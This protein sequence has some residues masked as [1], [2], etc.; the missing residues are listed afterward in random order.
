MDLDRMV[1]T[2]I[3]AC[4]VCFGAGCL[5][6]ALA[7]TP[8]EREPRGEVPANYNPIAAQLK[9]CYQLLTTEIMGLKQQV[10]QQCPKPAEGTAH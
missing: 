1:P 3:V 9:D 7:R 10:A 4:F 5:V 8:S 6:G 2:L